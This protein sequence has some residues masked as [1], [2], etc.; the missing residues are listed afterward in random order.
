M[1]AAKESH[2]H[3]IVP[4]SQRCPVR[5]HVCTFSSTSA[6]TCLVLA[7]HLLVMFEVSVLAMLNYI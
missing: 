2:Y 6:L 1:D 3:G 5:L 7:M 4:W